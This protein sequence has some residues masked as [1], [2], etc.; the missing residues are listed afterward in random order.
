MLPAG[1]IAAANVAPIFGTAAV[2]EW[3]QLIKQVVIAL[4]VD[5]TVGIVD[6]LG[7]S[8]DVKNRVRGIR[9]GAR[10]RRSDSGRCARKIVV[11]RIRAS[12]KRR[13]QARGKYEKQPSKK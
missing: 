9:L 8:G 11:R 12:G 3:V 6:P 2:A 7:R 10:S 1:Q 5:G 13:H 4:I